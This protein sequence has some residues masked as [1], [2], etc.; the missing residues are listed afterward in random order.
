[1]KECLVFYTTKGKKALHKVVHAIENRVD[2]QCNKIFHLEDS[3]VMSGVYNSDTLED[4]I[5]TV[6]KLHNRTTWD[7]KFF[8]G[9]INNWYK[10]YSSSTGLQHFAINSLLFLTT[11]REKYVKMYE[12]FLNQLRQYSQAIRVL[13]KGYL[14]IT[15][16]SPSKLNVILQKVRETVQKQNKNY[17]LL[18]K[19]L[20]LYY[21]MKLV[22]FGTDDKRN[23]MVWFPVF[24]HPY[25]QQHLTLYQLET[26]PVPIIDR[27]ENIQ[28]YTHLKVT[29]PYIT[30]NSETYISLRIQELETCKKI[31]YEFYCEE[32]FVVNHRSQH[33]CKSVIY[34][35]SNTE[36]IKE[37]CEFQYYYNK[38]DINPSVLD[39]RNE[40][41]LANWP[42]TKYVVCNDN[43]IK[44]PRHPYVLLKRSV[45]CNCDIHAEE[46][47]LLESIAACPGKQSDMTI[48]YTVNA[49]FMHYIDNF[50]EQLEISSL[51]VNQNWTTQEQILPI[52][53]HSTP[54][55][56]K[57]L[58]APE[59]L[60]GL[61]QQYRQK[62]QPLNI[63]ESK[64]KNKVFDNI[65]IDIFL[66]IAAIISMVVV[67]AIIH[68][69]CKHMKLKTLLAGIAF[70]PIKQTKAV[71]TSHIQQH[72][73]TQW[74]AIA[75]LT[76][77]IVLLIIYICLTTQRCTIFKRRLYSNTVTI[78]LFFSD[79]KQYI[80]VK[81]CKSAGSIHLFQIYGQL[82]SDQ[83]VLEK[84]CLWDMIRIN[85]KEVFVTLNGTM[86]QMPR[87]VKVPLRDKYKLR[88]LMEK[89]SLLLC[90]M[91]KQGT[92]WYALDNIDYM[93]PPPMEESE[94]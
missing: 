55:D 52:S 85:W 33:N 7:E 43:H 10:Y 56:N 53:L 21:G 79:V 19:R 81:L 74:Y 2:L 54:F 37:N 62:G 76:L 73:I 41:I 58:K 65:A 22:T 6:H 88:T 32:L 13:S 48:Y 72:C 24:I 86:V 1:M 38:T 71:V 68:I 57:L 61:V 18:I 75:A 3:M 93:L 77:M 49:A 60:K 47:S 35:D 34:F 46:H 25:N 91:L 5:D 69:V 78:M 12:R 51:D 70:Q 87:S 23:L 94:I 44:I 15:L 42:K 11:V 63:H 8:S 67:I 84:N 92:S 4:L 82:S 40:I 80:P 30:L 89:H 59:T 31:G 39:S 16:L 64:T 36:I 28:S 17:D 29:K 66:F 9:Q 50:K 45:L 26:V 90:D 20:Y 14:P 83:I 27:N